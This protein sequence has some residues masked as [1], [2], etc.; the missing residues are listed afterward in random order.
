MSPEAVAQIEWGVKKVNAP[1]VWAMG[2]RGKYVVVASGDT[3]VQWNHPAL[4]L[5]YRGYASGLVNH[6]YNWWDAVHQDVSG[7][8]TNPCGYNSRRPCDDYGH[9]THTVG[10]AVG[11]DTLNRI[12]VAPGARWIACRNMEEGYGRPSLYIECFQFFLA[13]WNLNGKNANPDRNADV[14]TNSWTCTLGSPPLGEGCVPDSL[15]TAVE[16]ARAAGIFVVA[17]AGNSGSNCSTID[18]PPAIYDAAFTVGATDSGDALWPLSSRGPVTSDGSGRLKP[19][20]SAPGVFVRSSF[21]GNRYVYM[22]G[23]SMAAPHVAGAVALLWSARPRL[24]GQIDQTEQVLSGS[25]KRTISASGSCGGTDATAI[26]NNLFGYGRLD[27]LAAVK[28]VAR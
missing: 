15:K 20:I 10:T 9:G 18:Q 17:S 12:G 26:P 14:I 28:S 21:P 23:T 24:K 16:S 25:A 13:P 11:G 27:V 22:S 5:H 4:K 2:Y 1:A 3:G 19:D 8:G 7:N 6:N